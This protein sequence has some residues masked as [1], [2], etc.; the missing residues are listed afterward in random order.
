MTSWIAGVLACGGADPAPSDPTAPTELIYT[1]ENRT[2]SPRFDWTEI[3]HEGF[4]VYY[5]VP[6]DPVGV[7]W[8]FHGSS[9][10]LSSV[11]QTEWI[12]IYNLL[13]QRDIA[14]VAAVST[15][16]VDGNWDTADPDPQT[17][18]DLSR[19]QR[20][21]TELVDTT[22]LTNTTPIATLAFSRGCS[23]AL[24]FGD[25]GAARGWDVRGHSLHQGGSGFGPV[26]PR[27]TVW[28]SAENDETGQTPERYDPVAEGCAVAVG[29]SCPH[30]AATEIPLDPLRFARLPNFS[31]EQSAAMF[32]ELVEFGIVD[33]DGIRAFDLVDLEPTLSGY[34]R[35]SA[36]ASPSLVS[37][38][39]RV[40][41]ATHRM[42]G[43]F[44]AEETAF[45]ADLLR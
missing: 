37:T 40:V 44:A 41:W 13:V 39:L 19:L 3:D 15:D 30:H 5:Y 24:L 14:L 8:V 7:V 36:Y 12:S 20:L 45:V 28:I 31:Q 32:D 2:V 29:G 21:H 1:E 38:Q 35:N 6:D 16:R 18:P 17:N 34:E 43:V 25:M 4:G 42:S 23:F 11:T 9:G 26:Y 22:R 10:G 33:P 27:P